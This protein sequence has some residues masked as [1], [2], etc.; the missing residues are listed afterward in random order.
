MKAFWF[1]DTNN[2]TAFQLFNIIPAGLI[3]MGLCFGIKKMVL[4]AESAIV[5]ISFRGTL[6]FLLSWLILFSYLFV[7]FPQI[8][9][10]SKG[11][12]NG[13][14]NNF[15]MQAPVSKK[16]IYNARFAFFKI[17][18]IPFLIAVIYFLGLNIFV[19][20]REF[21]SSY[22]SAY[23]GLLILIYCVWTITMSISIG[24]SSL[25]Y[26]KSKAFNYLFLVL[27]VILLV[28]PIYLQT[29]PYVQPSI[30]NEQYSGLGPVFIPVLKACRHIGGVSGI[31]VIFVSSLISY[32]FCCKL[33]L[34]ILIKEGR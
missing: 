20:R 3:L 12:V 27:V 22:L 23:S 16:D 17:G 34:K 18:S 32:F 5:T 11:K 15:L 24:F 21:I 13:N 8:F 30:W 4:Y 10:F 29:I 26:K 33:P 28:L 7:S 1:I 6:I 14:L 9:T 2:T 31:I 25:S 19:S